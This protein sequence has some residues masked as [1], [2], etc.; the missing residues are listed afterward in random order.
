MSTAMNKHA[1]IEDTV[2]CVRPL[3]GNGTLNSCLWQQTAVSYTL[4]V[5]LS[6]NE[7]QWAKEG[8][9]SQLEAGDGS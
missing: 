2:F 4:S 7:D 8:V 9:D 3:L 6:Y 1:M 5:P